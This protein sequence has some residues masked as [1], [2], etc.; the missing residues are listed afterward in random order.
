MANGIKSLKDKNDGLVVMARDAAVIATP[1]GV[2]SIPTKLTGPGGNLIS[3]PSNWDSFG[4]LD[5]QAGISITP[6]VQTANVD[7]YGSTGPRRT[8]KTGESVT[9]A[10]AAQESRNLVL[11]AFWDLD[12]DNTVA[13]SN[14]EWQAKKSYTSDMKLWS[15]ILLGADQNEFGDVYPYWIFPK[16]MVTQT[17]AVTLGTDSAL[18]Y[19]FTFQAFED[20][21][22]G[23]FMAIG[24]AGPGQA[25]V[26]AAA[27]FGNG[28]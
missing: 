27:G 11:S 21:S 4:E 2:G 13:D 24:S 14:G 1:Y 10:F 5:Q 19:P 15:L 20:E 6:D 26:N 18:V 28:S 8:V 17:D 25:G 9:L 16:V 3:L 12:L 22:F 23:G 7:G